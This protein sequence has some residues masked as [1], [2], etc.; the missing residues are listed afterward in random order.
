MKFKSVLLAILLNANLASADGVDSAAIV[1]A[2][3]QWRAEVGV[4]TLSY[5]PQLAASAQVWADS[6]K[7]NHQ[8]QMRHSKPEGKYG[9]NIYWASASVWTDGRRTLQKVTSAKPVDRWGNEKA[10]YDYAKNSCKSGKMCGHYTQM[11]WA[12]SKVVGCARTVCEDTQ[13][14]VWV[15]HYQPAGNWVGR[16]PY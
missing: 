15:C 6:L 3:N 16:R 5:S 8:C 9:E 2:H 14:Q 11:V 1:A 4:G 10:D 12:A 13:D 7:K